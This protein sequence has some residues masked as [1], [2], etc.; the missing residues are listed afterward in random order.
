MNSDL[1]CANIHIYILHVA[2]IAGS[3]TCLLS[4]LRGMLP[5][6]QGDFVH[7]RQMAQLAQ[8]AAVRPAICPTVAAT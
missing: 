3:A 2:A 6:Y 7:W 4:L 8:C 1:W 5:L